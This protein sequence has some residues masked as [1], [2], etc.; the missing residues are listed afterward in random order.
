MG[1]VGVSDAR[2]RSS[3]RIVRALLA[4]AV[5]ATLAC[6][7][8]PAAD[9]ADGATPATSAPTASAPPEVTGTSLREGIDVSSYSGTVDWDR[10]LAAGKTFAFAK[11]TEGVDLADPS[12]AGHWSAMKK[13]GIARG[14]YHFYVTEDDPAAQAKFFIETVDLMPG[15]LVPTVDIERIGH[16]TES[17][18]AD[19]LRTFLEAIEAHY[20]VR[21]IIYTNTNFWDAN[22][23]DSFGDYPLWVAEY[24]V[25]APKLPAGWTDWYLWQSQGNA[26]VAGVEQD[27]DLDR[28]NPSR[29]DWSALFVPELKEAATDSGA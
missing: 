18:L 17:G 4:L 20:G 27:A 14:A 9:S 3:G 23:D 7:A 22:L 12:F 6:G 16:G 21:P 28:G 15:D 8:A 5:F 29:V 1:P 10:V 26:K 19:R 13:A 2:P 24:G 11:A 25:D